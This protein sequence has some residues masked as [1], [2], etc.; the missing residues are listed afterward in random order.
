VEKQDEN[1]ISESAKTQDN[2]QQRIK[3][4]TLEVRNISLK[5]NI[6]VRRILD[7]NKINIKA[8]V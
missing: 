5:V 1:N 6:K 2:N 8:F 4:K 3:I 7:F